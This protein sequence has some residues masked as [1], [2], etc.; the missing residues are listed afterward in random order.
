MSGA[1]RARRPEKKGGRMGEVGYKK[2]VAATQDCP[3]RR[4]FV[5]RESNASPSIYPGIWL[6]ILALLVTKGERRY[7]DTRRRKYGCMRMR[8]EAG[9]NWATK[10]VIIQ[11]RVCCLVVQINSNLMILVRISRTLHRRTPLVQDD[12]LD[13]AGYPAEFPLK[14]IFR[15]VQPHSD[16]LLAPPAL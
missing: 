5:C 16:F 1:N 9:G 12:K 14:E 11:T 15:I 6:L 4:R 8:F 13:F 10:E 3:T 2:K 7:W